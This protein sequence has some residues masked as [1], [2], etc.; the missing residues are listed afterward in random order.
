M[1]TKGGAGKGF[2]FNVSVVTAAAKDLFPLSDPG[3]SSLINILTA[4]AQLNFG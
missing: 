3:F 2:W 4:E 1:Y